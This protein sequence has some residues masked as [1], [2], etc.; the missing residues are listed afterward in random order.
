MKLFKQD[1]S[2]IVSTKAGKLQGYFYDGAYIFKGVHYAEA[3][4]FCQPIEVEPWEG[5]K[6][7]TSYGMVCPLMHQDTPRGELMVPHAYWPMDEHCQNLNIWSTKLCKEAKKPVMVWLHGG[8]F[9]AGSSI[10]QLCYD[11]AAM[12]KEGDVV[13][14]TINHR[15]NLLG[16]LDLSPFGEKYKNSGNCGNAD[17]VA[18][19]KWVKENIAAFGGDP[20]NVT[21]FGQSGGGMKVTSL[22]QTPAADGLFHKGIVMSG[23]LGKDFMDT[24]KGDG[25]PIVTAMLKELGLTENDVEKLETLPYAT[26]V[27]AYEKVAE[28]IKKQGLYTGMAP[29]INDWYK[30]EP[31]F[32][33]FTENSK[34]IP[35]MVGSV[36]GEFAFMPLTFDKTKM[37]E[38]EMRAKIAD[39]FGE[40]KADELIEKFKKAYPDK[41]IVDL[42]SFD[43]IFR[44]PTRVLIEEASKRT[45]APVY[46]Y[47]FAL[48]F[49]IQHNKP[50][51]HCSDIAFFFHNIDLVPVANVPGVSDKLQEQIFKAVMN[52]A[53]TGDPNHDELP[54][55]EASKPGDE[56][57]MIFDRT[58]ECKHNF[59]AELVDVHSTIIPKFLFGGDVEIQ[60]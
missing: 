15:L 40:D 18:A 14:V 36:F 37:T 46:S 13:V 42:V 6:D 38:E 55:W 44:K 11:G 1:E 4:R 26:L 39:T 48:E 47:V 9:F 29:M 12:A 21:I 57:T 31:Q 50:A 41:K 53:R 34:K 58:C 56:A 51:W 20:D 19:L 52:F 43:S 7:A 5:I 10:E 32:V 24:G 16:Y 2:T 59:D 17:M 22:M 27:E 23:V 33:G 30:G 60:H 8:G 54:T 28:D 25:R 3:E 35:L 49:P 45:E